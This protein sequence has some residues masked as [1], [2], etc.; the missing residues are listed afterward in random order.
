M[1]TSRQETIFFHLTPLSPVH[2]GCDEVYEPTAFVIDA[3]EKQLISFEPADFLGMLDG[4]ALDKFSAICQKGT[5]RSLIEIYRFINNNKEFIDGRAVEVSAAFVSHF[6]ETLRLN[7]DH[8]IL[9]NL[10]KY[11]IKRTSFNPHDNRPYIPGSSIK[12]GIRTAVLNYRNRGNSIPSYRGRYA[13][14]DLEKDLTGGSFDSDPFR[15]IKVSDFIAVG[16]VKRKIIYGVNRKKKPSKFE[17]K[18]PEQIFEVIKP[19]TVFFGSIT[20]IQPPKGA[21]ITKPISKKEITTAL[22]Q[23]FGSEQA[24]ESVQLQ[25]VGIPPLAFTRTESQIPIRL[26]FHSGAECVTIKGQRK[27]KIIKGGKGTPETKNK[28]TTFWLAADSKKSSNEKLKPFGWLLL[29][30]LSAAETKK[31]QEEIQQERQKQVQRQQ[32]LLLEQE[33]EAIIRKEQL[34]AKQ[35]TEKREAAKAAD[36]ARQFE[37]AKEQWLN[38]NE[39]EQ[40]LAVI[41]GDEL[42]LSQAPDIDIMQIIWPKIVSAPPERQ[43]SLAAAFKDRWEKEG[44]WQ[45]KKKKKKQFEK[46]AMVKK[47]L[48]L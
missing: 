7:S 36:L 22:Y 29:K 2:I 37:K 16:E 3:T 35:E 11:Q 48:G 32:Q 20:I 6:Q 27:I 33:K 25:D 45:V 15:L 40:D 24:R 30:E 18:G 19:G 1:N 14:S 5:P 41:R 26:G 13:S 17:A 9:Q 47:I 8:E 42:A 31:Q 28:A 46:V 43:K 39:E 12:G 44:K 23:F 10:N 38:M 4:D 34:L 21:K